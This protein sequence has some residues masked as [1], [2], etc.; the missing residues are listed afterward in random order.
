MTTYVY[1][2]GSRLTPYM[3]YQINRLDADFYKEFGLHIKVTSAIRLAQ[4]QLNIWYARYTRTPNGRRVYDTRWWNGAL[5]YRVSSAGT[6]AQPGTSNHEIQGTRAA[7]DL[8]DTGRDAGVSVAGSRRSN[9]LRANASRY[10][11]VASG[12]GF[13]EAWHYD[14]LNIFNTPPGSSGGTGKEKEVIHY[15]HEDPNARGAGRLLKPGENFWLNT[16]KGVATSQATNLVR[17]V[18]MYDIKL[19]LFASGGTPGDVV[20]IVL[21]WDTP[22]KG[23]VHSWHYRERLIVDKDGKIEATRGFTRGVPKGFAVYARA[24][25]DSKNKGNIK[26]TV[27]DSDALL[28]VN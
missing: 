22:K 13:G 11:L 4:E 18:G 1:R 7:V 19:H 5:W 28:F 15:H 8:R 10:G 17:L 16:K 2:D 25:A 27:F 6:V 14:V 26:V 24:K 9:W 20:E 23:D 21:A 3:L 12:F